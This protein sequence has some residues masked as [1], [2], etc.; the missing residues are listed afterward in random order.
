MP[1][2]PWWRWVVWAL[3]MAGV[4]LGLLVVRDRLDKAHV[5][6]VY[7]LVVLAG[8]V[9]GGRTLGLALAGAAFLLFNWFFLPPFNTFVINDPFDWLV[10]LAFL[11]VSATAAQMLHRLRAEAD[12]A[13]RRAAEVD[14]FAA[15]GAE[16]LKVG[17]AEEAVT[18]V[19]E[20]IRQ[21][22]GLNDCRI[23]TRE[24]VAAGGPAPDSLVT[25]SAAHGWA[26]MRQADGTTR[27]TESGEPPLGRL[28]DAVALYLPLTV[29]S[30]ILGVLELIGGSPIVLS[31][32]QQRFL[33]A[34]TH[35]AALAV[36]RTRLEAEAGRVEVLREADRIKDALLASVSHDLRT[37]LTTIKALAHE[38]SGDDDRAM[39]I[40]EEADRLNRLV[41]DLLD[42]TRL[43][44]GAFTLAV[45]I[46]AVDDL[47]GALLQRVSGA[48][49]N[50][51]LRVGLQDGGTL[52]LGRFDLSQS[53]R[54]LVNLVENAHKYSLPGE[55]I[56]LTVAREGERLT[57]ALADR[58]PGVPA[59]QWE[60]IFEPFYRGPGALP[61]TGGTGLGLAIARQLAR[62][63]G[64]DLTHAPRPAGGT[65]FTL[66]LPAADLPVPT[67]AS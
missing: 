67:P 48:L 52:L 3:V 4:T 11:V 58:G 53:L 15:L 39:T 36:E 44:G 2:H 45:E 65:I 62:L 10:L 24:A 22:L 59:A 28:H 31:P 30:R 61:E 18:A 34:L 47:I 19:A 43:K 14:R 5:T 49:G 1:R 23:H 13:R 7:L 25:W 33:V 51:E 21:T 66:T 40:E 57:F 26:A 54:I 38:M 41:A 17:R 12:V 29:Q 50:R 27:L 46:N 42:L 20:V 64:G 16:A 8:T 60:R 35:Y 56:D 6:L 63:Q 55:R 32:A 37:P 9:G